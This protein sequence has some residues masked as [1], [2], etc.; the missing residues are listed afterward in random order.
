MFSRVMQFVIIIH[1][2][3][4]S[5]EEVVSVHAFR[6]QIGLYSIIYAE[7]Y[8]G[9]SCHFFPLKYRFKSDPEGKMSYPLNTVIK[10]FSFRLRGK[11][12]RGEGGRKIA[13][14]LSRR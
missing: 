2:V 13:A 11:A 8:F 1:L 10:T 14:Y 6:E 12:K 3:T 4:A 7:K 5:D 9:N